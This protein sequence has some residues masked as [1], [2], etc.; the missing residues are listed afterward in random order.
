MIPELSCDMARP[1]RI[2]CTEPLP[3]FP[4]DGKPYVI[5]VIIKPEEGDQECRL[6]QQEA[7]QLKNCLMI[8]QLL[9][10][11]N[12]QGTDLEKTVW[13]KLLMLEFSSYPRDK[14]SKILARD[15]EYNG[16]RYCFLGFSKSQLKE[17][18][19]FLIAEND[20]QIR[21]RRAKFGNLSKDILFAE[22]VAKVQDMFEPYEL[23][24]ELAEGEFIFETKDE[25]PEESGFMAP[26]LAQKINEIATLNLS[27]DP[28]VVEVICPGF[29]GKLLLSDEILART[30]GDKH[31]RVKALFKTSATSKDHGN[32]LTL[33]IVDYS[34]PFEVGYL[35]IFT[36]ML[37]H[38]QGVESQYLLELQREHHNLLKTLET[39]L[40]SA[41][42]FLRVNGRKELLAKIENG[43]T[44][45]AREIISK[46]KKKEIRK[47][48]KSIDGPEEMKVLVSESREVLGVVD[49]DNQ[50]QC[51]EC[52]FAP[53]LDC[54]LSYE[55]EHFESAKQVLVIPQPCYS[56]SDIQRF[57]L[58][59]R[60]GAYEKL[61]DC[62]VLPSQTEKRFISRKYIV[63]WDYPLVQR[64]HSSAWNFSEIPSQVSKFFLGV[65]QCS[66]VKSF[67][68]NGRSEDTEVMVSAEAETSE[69]ITPPMTVLEPPEDASFQK[70]LKKHFAEFKSSDDLISKAKSLFK[71]FALLKGSTSCSFCKQ[72][73]TYL[74]PSFDWNANTGKIDRQL[75]YLEK[76]CE[77]LRS[78]MEKSKES[79]EESSTQDLERLYT[80]MT[81][82]LNHFI[83]DRTG[84]Q[85]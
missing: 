7:E 3:V 60:I 57:N 74:S 10:E 40:T 66:N 25:N 46:I 72:L 62:I 31:S 44:P 63:C 18:K 47:M 30:T 39:D 2:P 26:E 73:G 12:R 43:M 81:T 13:K 54:L 61:K 4:S 79:A 65:F 58:C 11:G 78:Q 41:K 35:D 15:V 85:C 52:F 19:C 56:A 64:F 84:G 70:E 75:K 71:E 76:K 36:V 37:L 5:H 34:K 29:A 53:N 55:K 67:L 42:Y 20:M 9:S 68:L 48:E 17:K 22:R 27:N 33:C 82:N 24:L 45:E 59:R 14:I 8:D 51:D 69:G 6:L 38:C 77:S 80:A 21:E 83:T 49:P 28:S 16:S 50:L 1:L 23:S 32:A